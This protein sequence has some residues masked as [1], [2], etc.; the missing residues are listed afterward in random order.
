MS[1]APVDCWW[2]LRL[3]SNKAEY[4]NVAVCCLC[5]VEAERVM[6]QSERW[7]QLPATET[8]HPDRG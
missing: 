4:F 6:D 7:F 8:A 3:G 1:D 5:G 2:G